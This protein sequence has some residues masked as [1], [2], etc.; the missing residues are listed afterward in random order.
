MRLEDNND[1]LTADPE[2][3]SPDTWKAVEDFEGVI[4]FSRYCN[5]YVYTRRINILH[6]KNWGAPV[7]TDFYMSWTYIESSS[8][9]IVK[10]V[11]DDGS[12]FMGRPYIATSKKKPKTPARESTSAAI[13]ETPSF[14]ADAK[15]TPLFPEVQVLEHQPTAQKTPSSQLAI[16]KRMNVRG[17]SLCWSSL[18]SSSRP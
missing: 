2:I 7:V 17:D 8:S 10:S 5:D 18:R 3:L 15:E 12:V 9:S 11:E 4:P 1:L 16:L 6:T 13:Q 14:L